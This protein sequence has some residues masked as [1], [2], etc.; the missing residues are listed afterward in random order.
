VKPPHLAV[1]GAG[2]AGISAALR[3]IDA[4]ASVRV[5][6]AARHLGGRA[7]GVS[8]TL[9]DGRHIALDNG[10]HIL[11]GAY[12][13][14]LDLMR[15]VGV[16]PDSVLLRQTAT[17]VATS[18]LR[19]RCARLPRPL[20]FG[21]AIATA[22][23]I[24]WRDRFDMARL[25]LNARRNQWRLARD[26][27]VEQWLAD[28][29]QSKSICRAFWAPLCVA[30]L[31]TRVE[32]ASAQIFLNVM[33]DSFGA[34]RAAS[35][36]LIPRASLDM[37]LPDAAARTLV[38][39]NALHLGARVSRI[40]ING[41]KATVF[42]SGMAAQDFDG[43]VLAVA[44][45]QVRRLLDRP[46][47]DVL[48]SVLAQIGAFEWQPITTVYLLY[49]GQVGLST[50]MIALA[51]DTDRGRFGQWVFD[52]GR[53]STYPGLMAVVISADGPHRELSA[54]ELA[55]SACHQLHF[56]L[57]LP[58]HSTEWRV[59]TEKRATFA[60]LPGMSRP[61]NATVLPGLVLAGDYT[62]SDYPA[63]LETAVRSGLRAADTLLAQR[64][65]RG[66]DA[67]PIN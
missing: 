36:M 2:W 17:V 48:T 50:P 46:V 7:R 63:T 52:R 4:G 62:A 34:K 54:A 56:E 3:L 65:R 38:G 30:A 35:D 16:R 5:F 26:L 59:V 57:G 23:G 20:H 28:E 61:E 31:N 58:R 44:A 22:R 49:D 27:P 67:P 42:A 24:S 21:A 14:S 10:Q 32:R 25:F 47:A 19:L 6:E 41:C 8:W 29:G 18:G 60:C 13:D 9:A 12:K 53:L 15:R 39:C 40:E 1:V 33:R 66:I 55:D 11:L 43:V 45:H 64:P 37:V 51:E